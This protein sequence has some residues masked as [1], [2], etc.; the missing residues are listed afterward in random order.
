MVG[1]ERA[2]PRAGVVGEAC[3]DLGPGLVPAVGADDGAPREHRIDVL[4]CPVHAAALEAIL[5]DDLVG[6]LDDA[7]A[8]RVA[9]ARQVG[10][11][12]WARR[13]VR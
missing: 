3:R 2:A 8:D 11:S 7:A 6:A 13:A 1:L 9:A 10:Y 4:R 5:D 12:I